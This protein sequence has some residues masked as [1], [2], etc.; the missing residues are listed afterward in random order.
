MIASWKCARTWKYKVFVLLEECDV[1]RKCS[2]RPWGNMDLTGAAVTVFHQIQSHRTGRRAFIQCAAFNDVFCLYLSSLLRGYKRT[3][4][5]HWPLN[6]ITHIVACLISDHIP[7]LIILCISLSVC[8]W[9]WHAFLCL[10]P[11]SSSSTAAGR[12]CPPQHCTSTILSLI[13]ILLW[14][15][16]TVRHK[17][18]APV[19][20]WL[21]WVYIQGA[22]FRVIKFK[23]NEHSLIDMR[24]NTFL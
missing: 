19:A 1:F 14:Q 22:L 18:E 15:C 7:L 23:G 9:R 2:V 24:L 3:P 12:E 6:L 10:V 4:E 11:S 21:K 17:S 5:F 16:V 20:W 8:A 13:I